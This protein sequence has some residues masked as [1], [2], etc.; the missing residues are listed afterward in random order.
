MPQPTQHRLPL[1][2]YALRSVPVQDIDLPPS[3]MRRALLAVGSETGHANKSSASRIRRRSR[4]HLPEAPALGGPMKDRLRRWPTP[5]VIDRT[6]RGTHDRADSTGPCRGCAT[7]ASCRAM[8]ACSI[9]LGCNL[10]NLGQIA[11]CARW[12]GTHTPLGRRS[13]RSQAAAAAASIAQKHR[14]LVAR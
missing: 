13:S 2:M 14:H 3:K 10:L 7:A 5:V 4:Q 12:Y 6:R 9:C 1:P 11:R 8:A